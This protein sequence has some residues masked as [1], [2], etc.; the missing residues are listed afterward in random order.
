MVSVYQLRRA[1]A[2]SMR[3]QVPSPPRH[4]RSRPRARQER[5]RPPAAR[6][7]DAP[8]APAPSGRPIV[9]SVTPPTR[10]VQG[11]KII[12]MAAECPL[13]VAAAVLMDPVRGPSIPATP[14]EAERAFRSQLHEI[15]LDQ[16]RP[17]AA[18]PWSRG[19]PG[20]DARRARQVHRLKMTEVDRW[21]AALE[22]GGLL[23]SG[24]AVALCTAP[25]ARPRSCPC[26]ET[27]KINCCRSPRGRCLGRKRLCSRRGSRGS[28]TS[29]TSTRAC[30]ARWA[31]GEARGT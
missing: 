27:F 4:S 17:A 14:G 9:S 30:A 1:A 22:A 7:P 3:A 15:E 13:D 12:Q 5:A 8:G 11:D 31:P 19:G 2:S 20:A 21:I 23:P 10:A 24:A 25:R 28:G 29:T 16:A 26:R 6:A 18:R